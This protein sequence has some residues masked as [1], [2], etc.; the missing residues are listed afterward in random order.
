MKAGHLSSVVTVQTRSTGIDSV[1]Q[2]QTVWSDLFTD[3]AEIRPMSGREMFAA[4]AVQSEVSHQITMRYRPEWG[5]G[6]AT[7]SYR[8]VYDSRVF[9]VHAVLEQGMRSREVRIL[10]SEGLTNG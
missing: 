3:Y 8:I 1:G 9:D 6:K 2:Q 7:A 5:V 10:A 4:Q